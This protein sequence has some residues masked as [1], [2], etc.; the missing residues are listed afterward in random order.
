[1][2]K[3]ILKKRLWI[4]IGLCLMF[5]LS[6]SNAFAWGDRHG[7]YHYRRGRWYRPGWFGFD[8]A[9]SALTIGAVAEGLPP[10]YTTV[11]VA[12]LPYYYY[13]NIYYRPCPGGYIV[14][15]APAGAAAAPAVQP[16]NP[17]YLPLTK[18]VEMASQNAPDSVI[19]SEIQRTHSVYKLNSE[20]ITYLKQ[21]KVSDTVIDYMMQAGNK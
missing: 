7:R 15:P 21:N 1:M 17:Y 14:V 6:Y 2:I 11:V 3:I 20:I 18:I 9:V 19:I 13:D 4:V 8:V 10:G 12:G 16:V 5:A